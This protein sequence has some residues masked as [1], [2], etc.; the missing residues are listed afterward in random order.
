M[1]D[2]A[3]GARAMTS[4]AV[5]KKTPALYAGVVG[6]AM[7]TMTTAG[8]TPPSASSMEFA[9][10]WTTGVTGAQR[11]D[12][13]NAVRG[14]KKRSGLSWQQLADAFG[15]SR[16]SLHFWAND[17]NMAAA[18]VRRLE[19]L[20][21]AVE[22]V[23]LVDPVAVR[24]A[25]LAPRPGGRSHFEELVAEVAPRRLAARTSVAVQLNAVQDDTKHP[26]RVRSS[27]TLPVKLAEF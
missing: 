3:L 26:G 24:S 20:I 21:R 2:Y 10:V 18:S 12:T 8:I 16:R 14:L 9:Q 11:P 23:G 5:P 6:A 17:G 4:T 13:A 22:R 19:A 7:L 1:T 15:V 25:L 27:K